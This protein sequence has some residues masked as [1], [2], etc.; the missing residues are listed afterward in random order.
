MAEPRTEDQLAQ[1]TRCTQPEHLFGLSARELIWRSCR[2]F[3]EGS[4]LTPL[5][6]LHSSKHQRKFMD[7]G[8]SLA[9]AVQ[10]IAIP[11]VAGRKQT[12]TDRMREL[13][14]LTDAVQKQTLAFE[15]EHADL[16]EKQHFGSFVA[17]L[18]GAAHEKHFAAFAAIV[19]R[20][21]DLPG[22]Q[23]KLST[24]LD[25]A[26]EAEGGDGIAYVDNMIADILHNPAAADLVLGD[27]ATLGPRLDRIIE[28]MDG[29]AKPA[30]GAPLAIQLARLLAF[31]PMPATRNSL[32]ASL[33][34]GRPV[35]EPYNLAP[36]WVG[37]AGKDGFRASG[38]GQDGGG[39][40]R[41]RQS[42]A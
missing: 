8:S 41:G 1:E 6:L 27:L 21:A 34:R 5:E 14:A 18:E 37:T 30:V 40:W 26:D 33:V 22:W 35:T 10:K 9:A 4:K 36:G 39:V 24:V 28:L 2:A 12:V 42:R 7:A 23:E 17:H 16:L 11:Q 13:Y 32:R 25:L 15:A 19:A 38:G 31:N 20:L 29:T 3:L